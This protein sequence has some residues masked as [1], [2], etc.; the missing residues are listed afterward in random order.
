MEAEPI[1]S[2]LMEVDSTECC[3]NGQKHF[4]HQL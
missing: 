2:K 3:V 4:L 1:G